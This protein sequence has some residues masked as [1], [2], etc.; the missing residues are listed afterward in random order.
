MG[1]ETAGTTIA[2]HFPLSVR[3]LSVGYGR[4]IVLNNISFD[5]HR[6][7]ISALLGVNGCGKTTTL[8]SIV[9]LIP[10]VGGTILIDGQ[11]LRIRSGSESARAGVALVPEGA[12]SFADLSVRENLEMGGFV[13]PDRKTL[14][15]RIDEVI[16]FFPRLGERF[17][18]PAGVLSGGERQMLAIARALMLHP[19]V[20][21][22]DEPFLGLAPIMIEEVT[23]QIRILVDQTQCAVLI[24][25]QQV[26]A[27][28]KFS[29][30]VFGIV[31]RKLVEIPKSK[32]TGRFD[33]EHISKMIFEA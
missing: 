10:L 12:R 7:K 14:R 20:L 31:E 16:G 13:L 6:G 29:D 23:R 4:K 19:R 33:D 28:L 22:L 30:Q 5:L 25:E 3:D 1:A 11:N 17:L 32:S 27:T 21:L 2:A 8:K 15:N 24:A 18:I 9:R 26:A